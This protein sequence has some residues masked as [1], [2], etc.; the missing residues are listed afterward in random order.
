MEISRDLIVSTKKLKPRLSS[1]LQQHPAIRYRE[2]NFIRVNPIVHPGGLS[3]L[4]LTA[5]LI[6]TSGNA[7]RIASNYYPVIRDFH[8]IVYTLDGPSADEAYRNMPNAQIRK[9]GKN[10]AELASVIIEEQPIGPVTFF[11]GNKRHDAL[12]DLLREAKFTVREILVYEIGF[13][14]HQLHEAPVAAL[15]FSP[16]AVESYLMA[17]RLSADTVCIAIGTTTADL[18]RRQQYGLR[19]LTAT[20]PN[21]DAVVDTLLDYLN[22]IQS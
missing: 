5:P 22:T 2:E 6:F 13:A 14:P 3:D 18:L 21:Q 12:P 10:G 4:D 15:F 19:I 11:C 17:N 9:A 7:Q 1:L 20:S 8:G 16:S